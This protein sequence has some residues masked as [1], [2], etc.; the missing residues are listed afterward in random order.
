MKS[1]SIDQKTLEKVNEDLGAHML[2]TVQDPRLHASNISTPI[3]E[4]WVSRIQLQEK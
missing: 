4:P 2:V 1:G 3:I